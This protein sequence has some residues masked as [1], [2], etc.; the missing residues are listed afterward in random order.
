MFLKMFHRPKPRQFSHTPIYY[1]PEA[2]A[3][4][5]S[6]DEQ[7]EFRSKFRAETEKNTRFSSKRKNINLLIYLVLIS[8]V[9][10]LIFFS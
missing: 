1:T 7:A 10:Y 6:R 2:D 3:K 4:K 5:A 8:F 9:V